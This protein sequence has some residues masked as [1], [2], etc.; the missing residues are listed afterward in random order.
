MVE[1]PARICIRLRTS[2]LIVCLVASFPPPI[3]GISVQA[4]FLLDCLRE[5]KVQVF[6]VNY[7]RQGRT[8]IVRAIRFVRNLV[9]SIIASNVVHVFSASYTSFIPASISILI[10]RIFGRRVIVSHHD[11]GTR[12]FLSRWSFL[13]GILFRLAT[14][15]TVPSGYLGDIFS[16]VGIRTC[17]FPNLLDVSE[18]KYVE[19]RKFSPRLLIARHLSLPYGVR[20]AINAY[21][22]VK[23][24]RGDAMLTIVGEGGEKHELERL[25]KQLGL[26][27]V[28]FTGAIDHERMAAIYCANDIFLNCSLRDNFPVAILEAAASGLPIV[29]TSVGGIPYILQDQKNAILVSAGNSP[30]IAQAILGLI[31]KPNIARALAKEARELAE[32]CTWE[33]NRLRMLSIYL[34]SSLIY[35]WNF[36]KPRN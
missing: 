18:F 15:V 34:G 21:R 16:E 17:E 1:E 11:G 22:I 8:K 19:R 9:R 2:S 5:E 26:T 14:V 25:T 31:E 23:E 13:A 10:A 3:G 6:P 35:E 20:D 32:K 12:R 28:I 27:D 4:Q 36:R 24:K 33:K 29:T 30:M 7:N